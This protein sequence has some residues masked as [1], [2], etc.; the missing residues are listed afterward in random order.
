MLPTRLTIRDS[1]G[2]PA[3]HAKGPN[4]RS[5][6][7]VT[8][9]GDTTCPATTPSAE[10]N[11]KLS[12]STLGC[13]QYTLDQVVATAKDNDYDGV[14]IRFLRGE[15]ALEKL[16]GVLAGRSHRRPGGSWTSTAS[17]S[18]A[19]TPASGSPRPTP[20]SGRS[21]TRPPAPTPASP[22]S[23]ARRTSGSSAAPSPTPRRNARR[24]R[25]GSRKVSPRRPPRSRRRA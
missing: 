17:R 9:A 5:N 24:P 1:T 12:F 7:T 11:V 8:S 10:A 3:R 23:S 21:S 2:S 22:P 6:L 4:R 18:P 13:P 16:G 14:E 15:V 19:W 25:S 20:T